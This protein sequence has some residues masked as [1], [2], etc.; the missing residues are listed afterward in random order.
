MKFEQIHKKL[1]RIRENYTKVLPLQSTTYVIVMNCNPSS[2]IS[3]NGNFRFRGMIKMF[4][5]D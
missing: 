3:I 2:I 5:N 1:Q 4:L